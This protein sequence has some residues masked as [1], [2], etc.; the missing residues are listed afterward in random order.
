MKPIIS[1]IVPV[2][3]AEDKLERCVNSLLA[4]S[5]QEIEIVIVDDG[6][7]DKSPDIC[8]SYGS[9]DTR[10][11]VIHQENKGAS[12]ARNRGIEAAQ[13][14][15]IYF[16]DADDWIEPHYLRNFITHS[17][18]RDIII[19]GYQYDGNRTEV[20]RYKEFASQSPETV[21][22]HLFETPYSL[23]GV[24][25]N[26]LY[27]NDIIKKHSIHFDTNIHFAED[28]VFF[29]EYL[30]HANTAQVLPTLGYHYIQSGNSL[31]GKRYSTD[32][33]LQI[34]S[35]FITKFNQLSISQN[36]CKKYIWHSIEYWILYPNMKYGFNEFD[37]D[38]MYR[39][40]DVFINK[41]KL[42]NAPKR[43]LTSFCFEWALRCKNPRA[44]YRLI[45]I[46]HLYIRRSENRIGGFLCR[47]FVKI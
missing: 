34:L 6:S 23:V 11:K 32:Y 13:G 25:C 18:N 21:I 43:S 16:A 20:V 24:I 40:L 38:D 29:F 47:D 5:V 27:R 39:Q 2:Y 31:T 42:W 41:Y 9:S 17:T 46:I 15:W 1:V 30:L 19:Q 44:K 3:N 12:A 14:K 36:F 26:K 45:R 4:Q 7:S 37:F 8:D 33:Y 28:A 10:I 22:K 35:V